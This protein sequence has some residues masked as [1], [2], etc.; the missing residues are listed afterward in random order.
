MYFV[1]QKLTGFNCTCISTYFKF[2]ILKKTTKQPFS[3]FPSKMSIMYYRKGTYTSILF[4]SILSYFTYLKNKAFRISLDTVFRRPQKQCQWYLRYD[5]VMAEW[6]TA[7]LKC[8]KYFIANR[9]C[10]TT[11]TMVTVFATREYGMTQ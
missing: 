3:S 9:T 8:E 1:C 7:P 4:N 11:V 10:N 5:P 2:K 6:T